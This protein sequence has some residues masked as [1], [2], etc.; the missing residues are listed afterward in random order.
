[1]AEAIEPTKSAD[2]AIP[3]FETLVFFDLE[4]TDLKGP[5]HL[6][7]LFKMTELSMCAVERGH[8]SAT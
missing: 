2:A 7:H 4:T 6:R 5:N 1:M 8:F 3:T